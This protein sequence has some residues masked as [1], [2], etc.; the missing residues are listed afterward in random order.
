MLIFKRTQGVKNSDYSLKD[1]YKLYKET[2]ANPV[3]YKTFIKINE[4]AANED[5]NHLIKG[6]KLKLYALGGYLTLITKRSKIIT[7]NGKDSTKA[8]RIDWK[9][10]KEYW[11]EKYPTLS[12]E[13]IMSIKGKPLIYY[14]NEHTNGHIVN[15]YWL[16]GKSTLPNKSFKEFKFVRKRERELGKFVKSKEFKKVDYKNFK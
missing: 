12:Q 10:T 5:F 14:S 13:E 6:N 15:C 8:Y 16:A 3:D 9:S 1:A 2:S 4:F 7:I 11:I